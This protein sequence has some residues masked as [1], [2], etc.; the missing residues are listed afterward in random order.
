MPDQT[1]DRRDNVAEQP[2]FLQDAEFIE[3][4]GKKPAVARWT[5]DPSVRFDAEE[6]EQRLREGRNVG[7]ALGPNDLV[8]DVDPRHGGDESWL[9]LTADLAIDGSAF[10][11]VRTG[12]GG[13]HVYMRLPDDARRMKND[14]GRDGYPGVELKCIGRQVVAPGS[15]HP[16]T[17]K[18]YTV[19]YGLDPLMDDL[20]LP[21]VPRRSWSSAGDRRWPRT[22]R[23]PATTRQTG[24]RA[25][26]STSIQRSTAA[27]TR[28]GWNF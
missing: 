26:W 16:D 13:L 14:L 28:S 18:P 4:H 20:G 22:V 11:T 9:R 8:V 10:P 12:S 17:G 1:T 6:A 5:T 19:L 2:A 7:V 15:T 24:W 25:L 21:E 3:L 27:G 23:H